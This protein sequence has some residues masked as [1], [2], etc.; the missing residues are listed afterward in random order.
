MRE[1]IYE[2]GPGFVRALECPDCGHTR[3]GEDCVCNCDAARAEHKIGQLRGLAETALRDEWRKLRD[4]AR[5]Y[6]CA[7]AAVRFAAQC[8]LLDDQERELWLRRLLMCPGHD[9]EGGR[10]WCAFCGDM[11]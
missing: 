11:P 1:T 2:I 8:G 9:D 5:Y 10:S 4:D 3:C 6:D 7:A